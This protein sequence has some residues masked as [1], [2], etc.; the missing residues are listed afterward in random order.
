MC[1]ISYKQRLVQLNLLPLSYRREVYDLIFF[2]K[3][4]RGML[5]FNILDYVSY[6][7]NPHGMLTRNRA[8]GLTLIAPPHKLVSSSQFYPA[9]I[10]RLWN[11]LHIDLRTKLVSAAPLVHLKSVLNKHYRDKLTNYFDPENVCTYITA[12]VCSN[13]RL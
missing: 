7:N 5:A 10:A 4:L 13:C 6:P 11:S 3:S 9:R 8:L 12:C 1:H 2:V